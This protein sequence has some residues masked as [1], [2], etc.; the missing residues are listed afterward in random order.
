MTQARV[1]LITG[2][3]RGIGLGIARRLVEGG[4]Q[5]VLADRDAPACE[6]AAAHLGGAAMAISLDVRDEAA[7]RDLARTLEARYEGLDGLVNNAGVAD[8]ICGPIETLELERWNQWIETNLTGPFL[9]CKHTLPLLRSRRGAIVHI[10]STRALQSEPH[11]EAYAASK[12]GLAAFTHALAV[13]AGPEV[14]VNAIHPGWIDTRPE[15]ERR[16]EPLRPVDHRQ[17][18]VGRVGEPADVAAL[19]AFLLGPEAGFITGQAWAVDGGMT[20]RMIYAE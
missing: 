4:W 20:R 13:S 19:A 14:R 2:A 9:M 5:V 12:G 10:G 7:I 17:H 16:N 6:R 11:T 15:T 18:P 3:A 1:A 8:P